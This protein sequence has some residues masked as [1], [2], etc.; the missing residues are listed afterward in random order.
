MKTEQEIKKKMSELCKKGRAELLNSMEYDITLAVFETL[1]W[2]L[3]IEDIAEIS[4]GSPFE[5]DFE[6]VK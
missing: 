4:D 3:G 1:E 6:E 2:V 5:Y